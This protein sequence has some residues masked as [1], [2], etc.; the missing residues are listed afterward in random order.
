[1]FIERQVLSLNAILFPYLFFKTNIG[2]ELR[3]LKDQECLTYN[4]VCAS[5]MT[6]GDALKMSC[7]LDENAISFYFLIYLHQQIH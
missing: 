4:I 7:R 5:S 3:L 6:V 2:I 1:M